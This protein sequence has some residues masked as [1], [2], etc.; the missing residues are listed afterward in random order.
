M[1]RWQERNEGVIAQFRA[2]KGKV[3]GWAQLILVTTTGAKTGQPRIIPLMHVPY[4]DHVLAVASKGGTP[5]HP[6]WY[7]NLVTHPEVT[8]EVGGEKFEATARM[9]TGEERARAFAKAVEVFPLYDTYQK[10]VTREIPVFA[11][12]RRANQK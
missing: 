2:N 9:L 4:G 7:H 6:E 12:E 11:L 5:Q 10:K 3:Q 8:V 1:N